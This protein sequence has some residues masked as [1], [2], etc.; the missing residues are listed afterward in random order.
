MKVYHLPPTCH[1]HFTPRL[2]TGQLKF[3]HIRTVF[4]RI[5]LNN[6]SLLMYPASIDHISWPQG[7]RLLCSVLALC[8]CDKRSRHSYV[9]AK[10]QLAIRLSFLMRLLSE[11]VNTLDYF[12]LYNESRLT[13]MSS[14]RVFFI[15]KQ[16]MQ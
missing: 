11:V 12:T 10:I 16:G 15:Y 3:H 14:K 8:S 1:F 5:L 2:H 13:L 4:Q 9:S 7:Y 6:Q